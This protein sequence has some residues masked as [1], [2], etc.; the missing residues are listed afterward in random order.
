MSK[1]IEYQ[2]SNETR[3]L[4]DSTTQDIKRLVEDLTHDDLLEELD[5]A[6]EMFTSSEADRD[7]HID[8][9]S[10]RRSIAAMLK[11]HGIVEDDIRGPIERD[12][13]KD[14]ALVVSILK[15]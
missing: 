6:V 11:I 9:V 3:S 13:P 14:D 1:N 8:S 10:T 7:G 12:D 4:D 2:S 15:E 5:D